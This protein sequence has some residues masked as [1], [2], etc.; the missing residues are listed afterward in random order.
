MYRNMLIIPAIAVMSLTTGLAGTSV[1][2]A[3]TYIKREYVSR[4][5]CYRARKVPAKVQYNTRGVKLRDASRSWSG[6]MQADG[7]L[8]VDRYHDEV[9]IQTREVVEDQHVTLVRVNCR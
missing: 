8:V 7:A 6:N 1:S 5:V 4:D 3:E 9:Y 2:S